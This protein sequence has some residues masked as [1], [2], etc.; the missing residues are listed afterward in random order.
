MTSYSISFAGAGRVAGILSR[1]M[2]RSGIKIRQIVSVDGTVGRQL[3]DECN[4]AWSSGL[5]FGNDT[6]IVCK[7][8]SIK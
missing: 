6:D 7:F 4:A 2:F 3:A 5:V 8:H 1:E